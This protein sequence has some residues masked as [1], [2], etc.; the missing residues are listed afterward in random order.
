MTIYRS[1]FRKTVYQTNSWTINIKPVFAKELKA[2][3]GNMYPQNQYYIRIR[4]FYR[5]YLAIYLILFV[6]WQ[7]SK[8]G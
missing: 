8:M 5:F 4:N 3:V 7:W 2:L 6:A 1:R